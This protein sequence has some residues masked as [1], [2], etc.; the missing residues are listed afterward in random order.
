M[1]AAAVVSTAYRISKVR[2]RLTMPSTIDWLWN[3]RQAVWKQV[4]A[5]E[6]ARL[7][8]ES[9]AGHGNRRIAT[10]SG[11]ALPRYV[12]TKVPQQRLVVRDV[13]RVG[14]RVRKLLFHRA[15]DLGLGHVVS[16][17]VTDQLSRTTLRV[18]SWTS[19]CTLRAGRGHSLR[20]ALSSY[21]AEWLGDVVHTL[22]VP[23]TIPEYEEPGIGRL[24]VTRVV[25]H[26]LVWDDCRPTDA[27]L[28]VEQDRH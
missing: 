2:V 24:H 20:T 6:K 14:V 18:R 28:L 5:L 16:D 13:R 19:G 10:T 7:L 27:I 1:P 21:S 25:H 3:R 11:S 12:V 23:H 17:Q 4:E 15:K 9:Q 26:Q 8:E 22:P